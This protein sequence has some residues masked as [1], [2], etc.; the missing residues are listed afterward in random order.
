MSILQF[1]GKAYKETLL[2]AISTIIWGTWIKITMNL[3]FSWKRRNCILALLE[4]T[5]MTG[6]KGIDKRGRAS[7]QPLL[8]I[9]L[10]DLEL[11]PSPNSRREDENVLLVKAKRNLVRVYS[12]ASRWRKR[13]QDLLLVKYLR[14][15]CWE[16]NDRGLKRTTVKMPLVIDT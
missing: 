9:S 8:G 12:K 5:G 11:Q 7:G 13:E 10:T 15:L 3:V 2:L 1:W 14:I 4:C 6:E 16:I